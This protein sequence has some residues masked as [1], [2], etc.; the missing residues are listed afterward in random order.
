MDVYFKKLDTIPVFPDSIFKNDEEKENYET[1]LMYSYRKYQAAQY[2]FQNVIKYLKEEEDNIVSMKEDRK[3][4][5]KAINVSGTV[6]LTANHYVYELSAF[7]EAM[8]SAIDFLA[9]VAS[10]HS[11]GK[12]F[13]K[14]SSLIKMVRKGRI[15]R[16]FYQIES[17]FDWLSFIGEYRHHLVHRLIMN[18]SKRYKTVKIYDSLKTFSRPI[19]IPEKPIKYIPDTRRSRMQDMGSNH[20]FAK[21]E[22]KTQFGNESV[23]TH[24]EYLPIIEYIPIEKFMEKQLNKFKLFFNDFINILTILEFKQV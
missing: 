8:K 21:L 13:D 7:L 5:K 23:T 18:I 19:I 11:K 6:E 22:I 1:K 4:V 15:N 3:L 10:L 12:Q 14:I 9:T 20:E 17:Y 24:F 16:I 2:H